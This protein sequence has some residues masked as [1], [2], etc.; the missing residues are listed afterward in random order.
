MNFRWNIYI[1]AEQQEQQIVSIKCKQKYFRRMRTYVEDDVVSTIIAIR[2]KRYRLN[3]SANGLNNEFY[4]SWRMSCHDPLQGTAA[5]PLAYQCTSPKREIYSLYVWYWRKYLGF[6]IAIWC[7]E[8]SYLPNC[9]GLWVN[10][11]K[12][13]RWTD[14]ITVIYR[15][16]YF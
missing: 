11:F 10:T 14:T 9:F 12:I 15:M 8:L 4:K 6:T 2:L 13:N 3:W 5:F 16:I 7:D 1:S